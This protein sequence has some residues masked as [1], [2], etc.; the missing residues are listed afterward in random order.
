MASHGVFE[1]E[2]AGANELL[3]MEKAKEVGDTLAKHYPGHL[4]AVAVQGGV[5]A[6]K[7]LAI[8]SF[9]G[10][11]IKHHDSFSASDLAKKAVVA[12]GEMLERAGIDRTKPWDG[13]M[14]ERLEGSDPRFFQNLNHD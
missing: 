12:G 8:S 2:K 13:R 11:I 5:L 4:W 14:A 9:Y 6:V 1:I 3:D 10:F 7:N